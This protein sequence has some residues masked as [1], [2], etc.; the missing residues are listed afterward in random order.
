MIEAVASA[1][2]AG[3]TFKKVSY[4]NVVIAVSHFSSQALGDDG[5]PQIIIARALPFI[6]HLLA[7]L[8]N[9]SLRMGIFPD[10]WKRAHLLPLKKTAVPSSLSDFRPIALLPFLSKVLEKVAHT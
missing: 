6:G 7:K 2:E 4:D 5:F 8:F 9:A 10:I 3:F 1:A